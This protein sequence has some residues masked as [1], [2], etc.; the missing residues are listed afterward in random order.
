MNR[1]SIT[2]VIIAGGLATRM[3]GQ[4]KGLVTLFGKPLYQHV[5]DKILPQVT[6]LLI[7]ANRNIAIYQQS[8]YPIITDTVTGFVGPLA[9]ILAGL[10]HSQTEWVLFVPC[11]TP[12][13]PENL[14][15]Q[16]WINKGNSNAVYAHDGEREHPT[17]CLINKNLI[18]PL[19]QFLANG[20]KKLMLFL[21]QCQAQPVI[22][23]GSANLFNNL[24]T[25]EDCRKLEQGE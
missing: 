25:L 6:H 19:K 1:P 11:D 7:N 14:L 8:G 18:V 24:N 3:A 5:L 20:D 4:D 9:G 22:F 16:L 21:H 15:E 17:I 12:F 10:E 13:I 2:G 23:K